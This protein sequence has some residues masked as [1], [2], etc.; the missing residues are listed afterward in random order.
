MNH[1]PFTLA[2]YFFNALAVLANKFLL[3]KTIPDPLIYVFYISL[4]SL[5]VLPAIPFSHMPQAAVLGLASFST[6]LWTLGA[7]FMFKALK[8]ASVSRVIPLIGTLIPLILLIF[9]S[10]TNAISI[11]QLLA[12]WFLTAGMIFLTLSDWRGKITK[13]EILFEILSAAF[14][15]FSYIILREAYLRADFFSI[16]VWSRLVLLPFVAIV[17]LVPSLRKKIIT[18]HGLKLN[19][20]SG[21]GII[22]IGSQLGGMF[23]EL[24]LLFSISLANP[25]LVNS[26]QGTQYIFLLFF[27]LILSKRYPAFFQEKYTFVTALSKTFGIALIG[28]GLFLLAS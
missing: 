22:F 7:Y 23:S 24:L 11:R 20:L 19:I 15:A 8:T 26:L 1:I 12:V 9:A 25:V 2:A 21:S 27:A 16:L 17:L 18:A 6:L 10:E 5:L 3:N 28:V 14:F 4:A 13:Y